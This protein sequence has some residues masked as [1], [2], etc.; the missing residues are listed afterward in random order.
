MLIRALIVVA[1][2]LLSAPAP[3]SAFAS[4]TLEC[5]HKPAP[6]IGCSGARAICLCG[7]DGNC[8]RV[9]IREANLSVQ[10]SRCAPS[11]GGG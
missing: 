1:M 7:M 5:G 8:E 9:F 10:V 11:R 6:I 3:G 4:G 2:P